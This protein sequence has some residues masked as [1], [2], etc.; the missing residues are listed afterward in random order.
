MEK[1]GVLMDRTKQIKNHFDQEAQAFDTI[2]QQ[3]I[4][5]YNQ[6]IEAMIACIPFEKEATF[7]I[8]DLGCGTGTVAKAVQETYPNAQI[9]CLDMSEKMLTLANEKLNHQAHCVQASFDTF[10]FDTTYDVVLSSLALHHLED[11]QAHRTFYRQIY[12]ALT[13]NGVFINADV[14]KA[15]NETT[16]AVF[17]EKWITFMNQKIS[18]KEIE[19]RWLKSHFEEDR[20]VTLM[21]ELATLSNVGFQTIDVIYKYYNY[22]VYLG[23]KTQ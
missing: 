11:E 23:Q 1:E 2:I 9:T 8:I 14:I 15:T 21:S 12:K 20:P 22:A 7:S 19:E 4:P 17:M 3:I 10:T 6:M 18:V 16:Q 5:Y 13:D